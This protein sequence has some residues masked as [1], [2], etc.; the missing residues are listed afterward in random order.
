MLAQENLPDD[1]F[2]RGNSYIAACYVKYVESAGARVVPI[3]CVTLPSFWLRL[4][5]R[6]DL[7]SCVWGRQ[8][9]L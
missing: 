5:L 9:I 6:T 2:A 8:A 4:P 1:V 3:R 7:C